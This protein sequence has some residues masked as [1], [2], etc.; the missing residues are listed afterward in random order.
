MKDTNYIYWIF[1]MFGM[2]L[3]IRSRREGV[4]NTVIKF[5]LTVYVIYRLAHHLV[6]IMND[7]STFHSLSLLFWYMQPISW[8]VHVTKE[9][10]FLRRYFHNL[11]SHLDDE[12]RKSCLKF[13][14]LC[15]FTFISSI[16][17]NFLVECL[18]YPHNENASSIIF[19]FFWA[20]VCCSSSNFITMVQ[21]YNIRASM[22]LKVKVIRRMRECIKCHGF[23]NL[24]IEWDTIT[25][26]SSAF[27]SFFSFHLLLWMTIIIIHVTL[28]LANYRTFF[29]SE[30]INTMLILNDA[31]FF[32]LQLLNVF[33]LIFMNHHYNSKIE[34]E[35]ES[36]KTSAINFNR[37]SK[38]FNK[39]MQ[40]V[41]QGWEHKIQVYSAFT[42]NLGLI[43][44]MTESLIPMSV[45]V[46]E[47][48]E[49]VAR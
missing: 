29:L 32:C 43:I 42:L 6:L 21:I 30:S 39:L 35:V 3:N 24:R 34:S 9:T 7:P 19:S 48:S 14:L 5:A 8:H 44:S 45:L 15:F 26:R 41:D 17:A 23:Q 1:T 36:L 38:S 46:M 28:M 27:N 40:D 37:N 18:F 11:S 31:L 47:I 2:N 22:I 10:Y 13:S 49:R 16:V 4:M 25:R 20:V 12:E 33:L